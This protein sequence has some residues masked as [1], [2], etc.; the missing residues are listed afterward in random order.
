MAGLAP[1]RGGTR[2]RHARTAGDAHAD[3]PL[4]GRSAG[5]ARGDHARDR[6]PAMTWELPLPQHYGGSPTVTRPGVGCRSPSP[7]SNISPVLIPT[8]GHLS[9]IEQPEAF[10][11][12]VLDFLQRAGCALGVVCHL[13]YSGKLG[14]MTTGPSTGL[15]SLFRGVR[16]CSHTL[17][18][19][20]PAWQERRPLCGIA[21]SPRAT[22]RQRGF[23]PP[24]ACVGRIPRASLRES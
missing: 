5:E 8:A 14:A 16:T 12:A 20:N 1:A 6:A 19:H 10:N 9:D 15:R 17:R 13:W 23:S 18:N 2:P 21:P 7:T 22:L 4:P 24:A 3:G 11:R